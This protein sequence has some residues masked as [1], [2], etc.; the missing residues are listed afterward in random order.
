MPL[1]GEIPYIFWFVVNPAVRRPFSGSLL[2]Q[3]PCRPHLPLSGARQ[4]NRLSALKRPRQV[5]LGG[6]AALSVGRTI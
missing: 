2:A 3:G 4:T 1:S 6:P 5:T